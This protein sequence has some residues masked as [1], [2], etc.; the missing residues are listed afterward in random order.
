MWKHA[1]SH[2]VMLYHNDT[3]LTLLSCMLYYLLCYIACYIVGYV[4]CY[5]T[6]FGFRE[7]SGLL[8]SQTNKLPVYPL[9][10]NSSF[11]SRSGNTRME[12]QSWKIWSGFMF[13]TFGCGVQ[14]HR[15][16]V[17]EAELQQ[18]AA[19]SN[20]RTK[21]AETLKRRRDEQGKDYYSRRCQEASDG[22]PGFKTCHCGAFLTQISRSSVCGDI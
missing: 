8:T 2:L 18:T 7:E 19:I 9:L 4:R 20:A 15:V 1:I 13:L 5:I 3:W 22:C 17:A 12:L 16:T 14:P 6:C 10:V 11:K 21:A